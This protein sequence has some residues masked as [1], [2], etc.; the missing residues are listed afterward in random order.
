MPQTQERRKIHPSHHSLS[1]GRTFLPAALGLLLLAACSA[2]AHTILRENPGRLTPVITVM[3]G[4]SID[5]PGFVGALE[6]Y[7][8][9]MRAG[10]DRTIELCVYG[11]SRGRELFLYSGDEQVPVQNIEES[12]NIAVLI[13]IRKSGKTEQV[14]FAEAS[15]EGEERLLDNAAR[16]I[17]AK[18]SDAGFGTGFTPRP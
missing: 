12:M 10:P 6:P 8:A 16:K 1:A 9:G 2:C 11:H 14:L 18:L 15:A 5:T 17:A 4:I 7:F 3:P 13:R